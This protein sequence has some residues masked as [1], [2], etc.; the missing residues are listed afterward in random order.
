MYSGYKTSQSVKQ[1]LSLLIYSIQLK[2]PFPQDPEPPLNSRLS[3]DRLE[4][5]LQALQKLNPKPP[6]Q[7]IIL[8]IP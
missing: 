4:R 2:P 6:E 8:M 7:I 5:I 1:S 3:E